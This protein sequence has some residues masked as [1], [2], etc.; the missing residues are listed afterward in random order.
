ML[1][2]PDID[3]WEEWET[4]I[5]EACKNADICLLD[6]TF[7]SSKDLEHIGR[8]IGEVPHPLMTNTMDKLQEVISQT[9]IFFTHL[10]HSN[11]TIVPNSEERKE[12]LNRGFFIAEDGLDFII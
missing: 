9:K 2:I 7:H 8:D 1:Y 12:L 11:P 3:R 10:N 6:G 5:V 4:N